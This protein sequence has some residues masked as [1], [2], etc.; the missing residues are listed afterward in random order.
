MKDVPVDGDADGTALERLGSVERQ[1]RT[2]MPA[3]R[4]RRFWLAWM[5]WAV[6]GACVTLSGAPDGA[7]LV[8]AGILTA[9]LWLLFAAWPFLW[10]ADRLR[11][12]R[13]WARDVQL[14]VADGDGTGRNGGTAVPVIIG[15]DGRI[16]VPVRAW[17]AAF[18]G[19][20]PER[21]GIRVL[22]A[23]SLPGVTL[24]VMEASA[25]RQALP[26]AIVPDAGI[27]AARRWVGFL[28]Q[29]AGSGSR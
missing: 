9:P 14:V 21:L 19:L 23:G 20:V 13:L 18:P 24:D 26:E 27:V 5:L 22:P 11:A 16:A 28:T 12:R 6:F 4:R 8:M 17:S 2:P 29:E 3:S 10:V 7:A 1:V 25:M 15:R